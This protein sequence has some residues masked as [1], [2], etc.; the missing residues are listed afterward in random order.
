M[1]RFVII[2]FLTFVALNPF[3]SK[4]VIWAEDAVNVTFDSLKCK[5]SATNRTED[6]LARRFQRSPKLTVDSSS[7][8]SSI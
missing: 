3:S 2:T 5:V 4:R 1:K 7:G 6:P 8:L